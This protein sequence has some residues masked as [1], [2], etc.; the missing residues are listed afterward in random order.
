MSNQNYTLINDYDL[1]VF[2]LDDTLV[3]TEEYHYTSWLTILKNY[4]DS[5]FNIDFSTFCSKFHSNKKDSIKKYIQN[6]LNIDDYESLLKEKNELY[7]E[8]INKEKSNIKL[9]DGTYDFLE[10][11]LHSNKKFVIVSNSLKSNI[12]FFLELFPILKS[13]SKNYYRELY[14]NKKPHPECYLKVLK[15]FSNN[16]IIGFEDSITG[17]HSMCQ[18]ENIDTI[19][20][21]NTDYYYYDY[22][23]NTYKIKLI[24]KNYDCLKI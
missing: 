12:D 14:E 2:D 20:I 13:S 15:D 23:I 3:K 9:I 10:K 4:K 5:N 16:K 18:V 22:I 7:L 21:N 11:I 19:F 8:I 6:E 17:I 24:I 1:F